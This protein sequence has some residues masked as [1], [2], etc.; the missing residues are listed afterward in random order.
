MF[1]DLW[2]GRR[3]GSG[4]QA[5]RQGGCAPQQALAALGAALLLTG[6]PQVPDAPSDSVVD[7]VELAG[8]I[9]VRSPGLGQVHLLSQGKSGVDVVHLPYSGK[10][11]ATVVAPDRS[12]V[13][14][15]DVAK[16][17]LAA[18]DGKTLQSYALPSEF[19][20]VRASDDAAAAVLFHPA[21]S[22]AGTSIVNSDEVALV[23]L[24][25]PGGKDNP[26][27]ATVTG[28]TR[29]PLTAR[30]APPISAADGVHR[31][32][33]MEAQG[34][35]GIVDF[36][37]TQVRTAVVPLAADPQALMQPIRT[38]VQVA[39]GAA[40]LYLLVDA[41][42]DVVHVRIDVS[43]AALQ[44][45]LDQI[46]A[47]ADPG[48][49][50]LYSAAEGLR[51]LVANVQAKS[52]SVLDPA[53]GSG[54]ELPIAAPVSRFEPVAAADGKQR[55]LAWWH[56][57]G[58]AKLW[59][60]D[61]DDLAKKKG[62]AI[63]PV[64]LDLPLYGVQP[65]GGQVVLELKS[66][67]YGAALLDVLTGKVTQFSGAG[68]VSQVRTLGAAG[69]ASA[70]LLGSSG[71]QTRLSR[72]ALSDQHAASLNLDVDGQRL[73]PL[74]DGVALMGRSLAGWWLAFF[75]KGELNAANASWL[76]GFGLDGWAGR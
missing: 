23:D 59:I 62:K 24:K 72:I 56:V 50:H 45:S 65:V 64:A 69:S 67:Q 8:A 49:L 54:F 51:V 30:V 37:P 2:H 75:A 5:T 31:L 25:A 53:T 58:L 29:A 10:P 47:G 3:A 13:L 66:S 34:R 18:C 41:L 20:G 6:C 14:W 36:G 52:L 26:R 9:A 57:G 68:K 38:V 48:D 28:L 42:N 44:I 60:I 71:G 33:W 46:A 7:P 35:L 61:L 70:W 74:G 22:A 21:G 16:R 63:R 40:D 32:V 4:R 11:T 39:P 17:S 12:R 73:L 19:S 1:A 76:E 55:V 43:G 27:V 15:L